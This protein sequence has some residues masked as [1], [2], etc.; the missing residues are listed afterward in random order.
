MTAG[1]KFLRATYW[2]APCEEK[3][4]VINVQHIRDTFFFTIPKHSYN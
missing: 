4:S 2:F 1:G 3:F